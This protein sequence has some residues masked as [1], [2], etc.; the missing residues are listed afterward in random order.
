[1]LESRLSIEEGRQSGFESAVLP[2]SLREEQKRSRVLLVSEINRSATKKRSGAENEDR[3]MPSA[4]LNNSF[5]AT[6]SEYEM[7]NP[8]AEGAFRYVARG[9]YVDGHRRGQAAVCKWFKTGMVFSE[10]F[11]EKDI[12]AVD[13][14]LEIVA[15]FNYAGIVDMNIMLNVPEVWTSGTLVGGRFVGGDGSRLL[16]EPY[17]QNYQ[18]FNSNTVSWQSSSSCR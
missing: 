16:V 14:A 10:E 8:F 13:K 4:R 3:N 1:M 18:K 5:N 7:E 15:Q 17:V 11:F 2:R 9:Q 12:M 6:F